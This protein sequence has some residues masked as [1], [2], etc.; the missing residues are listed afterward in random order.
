MKLPEYD[1]RPASGQ[2]LYSDNEE[3]WGDFVFPV[4]AIGLPILVIATLLLTVDGLL[5]AL[6]GLF[7]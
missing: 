3:S 4:L 7:N 1:N 6:R 5:D 2:P